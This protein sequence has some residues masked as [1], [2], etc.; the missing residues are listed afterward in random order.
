MSLS[1][2]GGIRCAKLRGRFVRFPQMV[3]HCGYH[4]PPCRAVRHT[5]ARTRP[6]GVNTFDIQTLLSVLANRRC[7]GQNLALGSELACAVLEAVTN[8]FSTPFLAAFLFEHMP[9]NL[10]FADTIYY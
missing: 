7:S 9:W 10:V 3:C 4:S 6:I 5:R 1:Y 8:Y 2:S